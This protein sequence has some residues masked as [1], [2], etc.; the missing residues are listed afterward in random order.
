MHHQHDV[1]AAL[2]R[3]RAEIDQLAE[4]HGRDPATVKLL[5]VSKTKPASAVEAALAAGQLHFGEN[6]LQ[7]AMTKIEVF[8]EPAVQWHFIGG[9]QSN[10]TRPVAEHFAWC[11]S[12][13]RLKIA[14]RQSAQRPEGLPP[15][16]LCLQINID[17]EE[18]KSGI[19]PDEALSLATAIAGL[20][21][22][23]LRGL[24]A[25]P[26]PRDTVDA[27]REPF[28]RLRE[29]RDSI[30]SAGLELDTLSMGMTDDMEAAIAE[31]STMVR[32]GTAIFGRRETAAH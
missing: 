16:N 24:M 23:T 27:Q 3:V 30:N 32:I 15:L 1:A 8:P 10:K 14:Q 29:L 26:K 20:P 11:H 31:G 13:D 28:R 25:I 17:G 9:L 21:R 7:D 6:H 18:T 4:R 5:A 22:V 12:V 2:G 19:Q